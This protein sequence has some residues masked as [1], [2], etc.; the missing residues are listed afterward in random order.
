MK[1]YVIDCC[2]IESE[3]EF[4][5]SY[6]RITKPEGSE[7]F[8]GN[9]DAFWDALSAGGPGFPCEEG[10]CEIQFVNLAKVKLFRAGAFYK[11]LK[12]IE[13]DLNFE[14]YGNVYIK[15]E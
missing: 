10:E 3:K 7:Y 13:N 4:W 1:V 12:R 5:A 2:N 8:G 14:S 6:L 9:L 15:V 11:A